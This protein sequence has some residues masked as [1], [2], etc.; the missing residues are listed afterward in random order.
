VLLKLG[1]DGSPGQ[2]VCECGRAGC[3]A[4][5]ELDVLEYEAIRSSGGIVALPGH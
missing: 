5:I 1:T 2:Y 3:Y 4:T